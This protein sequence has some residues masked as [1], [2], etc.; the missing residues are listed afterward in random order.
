[1]K[2]PLL[3]PRI[4]HRLAWAS[5]MALACHA[6]LAEGNTPAAAA[7]ETLGTLLFTPA[8]REQIIRA[9]Q[10]QTQTGEQAVA[11]TSVSHLQGVVRRDGGNSTVWINGKALPQGQAQTPTLQG[12]DALVAGR[13]LRVGEAIDTLSGVRS[14]VVVPGTVTIT[15]PPSK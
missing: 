3:L 11:T 10:P 13:R 2:T 4:T 8:Q 5:A 14:D 7:P 12:V 9:R 1:M 15:K 6:A